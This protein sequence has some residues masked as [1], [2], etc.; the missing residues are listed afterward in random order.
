M[1]EREYECVYVIAGFRA[2]LSLISL[3]RA[4]HLTQFGHFYAIGIVLKV[5]KMGTVAPILLLGKQKPTSLSPQTW[6]IPWKHTQTHT[7]YMYIQG[8]N[9][10]ISET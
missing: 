5:G 1:W 4:T 10:R 7:T 6:I 3:C 2:P 8:G 9:S